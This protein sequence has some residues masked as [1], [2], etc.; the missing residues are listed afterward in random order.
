[1]NEWPNSVCTEALYQ[2]AGGDYAVMSNEERQMEVRSSASSQSFAC[3]IHVFT[4]QSESSF[5]SPTVAA[6]LPVSAVPPAV[7]DSRPGSGPPR[8]EH[9]GHRFRY[10]RLLASRKLK[11]VHT[12]GS[13][14]RR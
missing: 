11:N 1:M 9:L 8:R 4:H 5:L 6:G 14:S 13:L 10:R 12:R 3:F 2:E 7:Q